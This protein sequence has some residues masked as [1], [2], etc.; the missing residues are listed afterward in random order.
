MNVIHKI[1]INPAGLSIENTDLLRSEPA[2][3]ADTKEPSSL[4]QFSLTLVEPFKAW[5]HESK[6]EGYGA[7]NANKC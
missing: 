6:A 4:F 5:L 3:K 7:V 1:W 2:Y